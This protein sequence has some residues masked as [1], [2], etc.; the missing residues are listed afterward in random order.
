MRPSWDCSEQDVFDLIL[1]EETASVPHRGIESGQAAP[2]AVAPPPM[3]AKGG[4][5][6][7]LRDAMANPGLPGSTAVLRAAVAA[8]R[9][10]LSSDERR[11][12]RWRNAA[13]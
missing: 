5:A 7:S 6:P 8:K 4:A 10:E 3:V 12:R 11:Y 2:P 9:K 13:I 1:G